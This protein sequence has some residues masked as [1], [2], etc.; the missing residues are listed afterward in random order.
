MRTK[1]TGDLRQDMYAQ[2][3]LGAYLDRNRPYFSHQN[4][5]ELLEAVYARCPFSKA[6]LAR[7]SNMS[8]I[9][10][11]QVFSGRRHPSR[12]RLLSLC[13]GMEAALEET[14]AI[15]RAASFS[16]LYPRFERDSIIAHGIIHGTALDQINDDLLA[17]GEQPLC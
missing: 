12:D 1:T 9:Y 15:L 14:Q 8:E 11:Y 10:V 3:D 5:S 13:I 4:L 6:A 17:R 7:R 16:E 2:P